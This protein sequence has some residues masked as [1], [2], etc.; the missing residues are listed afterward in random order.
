MKNALLYYYNLSI[1]TIH[2]NENKYYFNV[3]NKSYFL[4]ECYNIEEINEI[5]KLNK[6]LSEISS[7]YK[8]VLNKNNTE[9]T[10]INNKN[11]ILIELN[12]KKKQINLSDIIELNNIYIPYNKSKLRRD[13]WYELWT[14]KVDYIEYQISQTGKKYPI[15]R[16]SFNYYI[17]LAETA[18]A[19][20]KN[21]KLDNIMLGL[22]HRRIKMTA[23]DL[24][25]PLNIII[26]FRMRDICEYFKYCFFQ[27]ID[28]YKELNEFLRYNKLSIEE[29]RLFFAR[30]LFPTYYFDLYEK[31]INENLD[32]SEIKKIIFKV[33]KYEEILQYIYFYFKNN[34]LS[35][36][37]LEKINQY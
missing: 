19:I 18:I 26:D 20:V 6:Y 35:I 33:N 7:V 24:Y 34:N 31:I 27:N 10:N 1:D 23:F 22:C 30:M 28:I 5:Y 12:N 8:I 3:N 29:S 13:N 21:T 14:N 11:Y 9:I 15:I 4:I 2:Q 16:D 37:W 32:E 17:G 36:E 25:N